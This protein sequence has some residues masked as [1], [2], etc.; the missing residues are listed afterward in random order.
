MYAVPMHNW[1]AILAATGIQRL[2]F[3]EDAILFSIKRI[4]SY[5]VLTIPAFL[6]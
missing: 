6:R 2:N 4:L 1:M 5:E 3:G